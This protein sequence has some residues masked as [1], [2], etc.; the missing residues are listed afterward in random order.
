M[1]GRDPGSLSAYTSD[2][3]GPS[4]VAHQPRSPGAKAL[5]QQSLR[6]GKAFR[7]LWN[8]FTLNN[9]KVLERH[10]NANTGP[11]NFP[12]VGELCL[13]YPYIF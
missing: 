10:W 5:A 13:Y 8:K 9:F 4:R 7:S 11:N 1:Y 6:V 3:M 2:L 12:K